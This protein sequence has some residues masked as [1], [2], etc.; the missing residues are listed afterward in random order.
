MARDIIVHQ[1]EGGDC[2]LLVTPLGSETSVRELWSDPAEMLGLPLI[3]S[4][5]ERGFHEGIQWSGNELDALIEE[6]EVFQAYWSASS[7]GSEGDLQLH[8][9]M[10]EFKSAIE[11]A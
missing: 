3:A 4:I 9:R 5:Y 10:T 7:M 8:V 6:L 11:L 1:L 2:P